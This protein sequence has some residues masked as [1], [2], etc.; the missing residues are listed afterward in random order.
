MTIEEARGH[1]HNA[2]YNP[3]N[4]SDLPALARFEGRS[5]AEVQYRIEQ[6]LKAL[7]EAV[8]ALESRLR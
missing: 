3:V 4:S 6:A 1:I 2:L 7:L 8:E 5:P